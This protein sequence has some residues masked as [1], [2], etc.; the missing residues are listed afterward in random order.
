M[1]AEFVLRMQLFESI[2]ELASE[3]FTQ[4][5]HRQEE[6]LLR[7]DPLRVV[8]SQPAGWNH[9]VDVRMK[10]E[11]LVPGVQDAEETDLGAEVPRI[12]GD[13]KQ[14]LGAGPEQ[15]SIDLAFIHQRQWRKL[16]R[17]RK[18]HVNVA[19]GQEFFSPRFQPAVASVSLALR[20]MPVPARVE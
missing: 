15:E 19:R 10:L 16:T 1:E 8:G 9:T 6:F 7:V 2:H 4:N 11:F 13:L 20:A 17:Q 12:A 14:R 5:V 18:D 3:H